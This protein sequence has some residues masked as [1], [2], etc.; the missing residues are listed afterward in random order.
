MR[1]GGWGVMRGN[2][3]R[4]RGGGCGRWGCFAG[5]LLLDALSDSDE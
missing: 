4:G 3:W 1:G 5:S 2:E